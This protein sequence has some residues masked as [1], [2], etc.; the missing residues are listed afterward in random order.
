MP[1]LRT[2]NKKDKYSELEKLAYRMGQVKR[3]LKNPD[4]KISESFGN[5]CAVRERKP[6]KTMF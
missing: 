2:G 6:R 3:G 4:S 1:K 5:G